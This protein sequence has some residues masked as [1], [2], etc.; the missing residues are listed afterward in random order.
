MDLRKAEE[1]EA[2]WVVRP[3]ATALIGIGAAL[4]VEVFGPS[5]APY[6]T[7][8]CVVSYLMTGH[9]S[10][11]PSQILSVKKSTFLDVELGA[12]LGKTE[13]DA[14]LPTWSLKKIFSFR[15]KAED[16]DSL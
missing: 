3:V 9:R 2:L 16:P 5:I 7:V 10:V 12:E 11:Y 6:A 15:R 8:A 1:G 14:T 13:A 4:A